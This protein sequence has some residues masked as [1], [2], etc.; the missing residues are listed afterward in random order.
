MSTLSEKQQENCTKT[1]D[2]EEGD[3]SME[4]ND[5]NIFLFAIAALVDHLA[6]ENRRSEEERS[7]QDV[8]AAKNEH[9]R[10]IEN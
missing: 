6:L 8:E 10:A 9:D 4:E 1:D 2:D 7:A 3:S 5:D